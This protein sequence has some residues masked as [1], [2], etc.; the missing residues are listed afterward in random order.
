[1]TR[2]CEP[3]LSVL[4]IRPH[5]TA[6]A[7]IYAQGNLI[8]TAPPHTPIH[9]LSFLLITFRALRVSPLRPSPQLSRLRSM[10]IHPSRPIYYLQTGN[11]RELPA[12]TRWNRQ[13]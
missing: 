7:L 3:D 10:I 2:G 8:L 1:M 5:R 9:R 13:L 12:P 11:A 6:E 4:C